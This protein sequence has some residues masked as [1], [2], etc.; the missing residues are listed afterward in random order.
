MFGIRP[1]GQRGYW[2]LE[3]PPILHNGQMIFAR[4]E[5]N[6]NNTRDLKMGLCLYGRGFHANS[7]RNHLLHLFSR[8]ARGLLD[9]EKC[10]YEDLL[11][12]CAQ[13]GISAS[14]S[15][16]KG[17][18][19]ITP[20]TNVLVEHPHISQFTRRQLIGALEKADEEIQLTGFFGLLP[21]ELRCRVYKYSFSYFFRVAEPF[22]PPPIAQASQL[23]RQESL[24]LFYQFHQL[25]L[26]F[27]A[28]EHPKG[29]LVGWSTRIFLDSLPHLAKLYRH[30]QVNVQWGHNWDMLDIPRSHWK[31]SLDIQGNGHKISSCE[32]LDTEDPDAYDPGLDKVIKETD[33]DIRRMFGELASRVGEEQTI[34]L[35]KED[36]VA[37]EGIF[38]RAHSQYKR[39]LAGNA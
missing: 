29:G 28:L 5:G 16:G 2:R 31:I 8:L 3:N 12:F 17:K 35:E 11:K 7:G 39:S 25:A 20:V 22:P 38:L 1:T 14:I 13:R 6:V 24:P 27:D 21:A 23:A 9:Y 30:I 26:Y 18:K 37:L 34:E 33:A 4:L 15:R 19:K 36:W 32:D 10:T